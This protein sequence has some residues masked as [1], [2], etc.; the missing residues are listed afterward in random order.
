[1]AQQA[2]AHVRKEPLLPSTMPLFPPPPPADQISSVNGPVYSGIPHGGPLAVLQQ[3]YGWPSIL[4][5]RRRDEEEDPIYMA[6]TNIHAITNSVSFSST[7]LSV[8]DI[9]LVGY[10]EK[11]SD[12]YELTNGEKSTIKANLQ[13]TLDPQSLLIFNL[14][15]PPGR[16]TATRLTFY[17]QYRY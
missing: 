2:L 6:G 4:G 5:K 10:L 11:K 13:P 7:S 9:L 12:K 15:I 17:L 14:I 16:S 1:M 3:V 8:I